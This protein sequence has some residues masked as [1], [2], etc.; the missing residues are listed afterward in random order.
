MP[1]S[2]IPRPINGA[3]PRPRSL[4][5]MRHS[6]KAARGP[7]RC[8]GPLDGLPPLASGKEFGIDRPDRDAVGSA[9]RCATIWRRGS[10]RF[11]SEP[12]AFR[13]GPPG[14]TGPPAVRPASPTTVRRR[15]LS[16]ALNASW[17]P[18]GSRRPWRRG[19]GPPRRSGV[20]VVRDGATGH[21]PR[22]PREHRRVRRPGRTAPGGPDADVDRLHRLSSSGRGPP[23]PA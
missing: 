12:L 6:Q 20:R 17:T 13:A 9:A 15:P 10:D 7:S 14:V 21:W 23:A 8:R 4:P 22:G 11:E 18:S 16:V 1:T 2:A 5:R 19:S 3:S